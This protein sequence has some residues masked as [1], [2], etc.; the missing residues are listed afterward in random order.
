MNNFNFGKAIKQRSEGEKLIGM[1]IAS[2]LLAFF[3]VALAEKENMTM[4][5][6][7]ITPDN[8]TIPIDTAMSANM[9][10]PEMAMPMNKTMPKKMSMPMNMTMPMPMDMPMSMPMKMTDGTSIIILQN[11]TLNIITIQNMTYNTNESLP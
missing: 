7:T 9:T 2:I 4:P 3:G 8:L 10:L 5:V 6:D 11:L 1:M